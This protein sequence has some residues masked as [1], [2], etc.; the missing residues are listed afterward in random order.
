[1]RKTKLLSIVAI[2]GYFVIFFSPFS[3]AV[4]EELTLVIG[5]WPPHVSEKAANKGYMSEIVIK[6]FERVG[7]K[8]NLEFYPWKRVASN[9]DRKNRVSFSWIWS[10]ERSKKW[11]FSEAIAEGVAVFITKKDREIHWKTLE[12]LKS[13]EI[14]VTGGYSYG[15]DFDKFKDQLSINTVTSD[16]QNL[17][18][19]LKGRID[20]FPLNRM[21]FFELMRTKFTKKEREQ[22]KLLSPPL[23][24][25]SSHVIC[26]KTYDKCPYFLIKFNEGVNS[27]IRDGTRQRIINQALSL[28]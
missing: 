17:R 6:S 25:T 27:L 24:S 16:E 7:I 3:F 5:D 20:L 22:F 2:S 8:A 15:D 18:K 1:M 26:A 19:L 11:Y 13:Y 28:E 10:E 4:A 23:T 9:V 12:D 21:N 14:G